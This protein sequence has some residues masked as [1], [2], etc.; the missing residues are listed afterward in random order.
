MGSAVKVSEDIK[1]ITCLIAS[2]S[3]INEDAKREIFDSI[4]KYVQPKVP[5]TLKRIVTREEIDDVSWCIVANSIESLVE[6]LDTVDLR[7]DVVDV[8]YVQTYLPE[9]IIIYDVTKEYETY[10]DI[11]DE[12]GLISFVK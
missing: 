5:N 1:N 3:N 10:V 2:N 8:S 7:V 4:V 6:K 9:N 12:L 11:L